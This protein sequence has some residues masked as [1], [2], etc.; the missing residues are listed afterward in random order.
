MFFTFNYLHPEVYIFFN[1]IISNTFDIVSNFKITHLIILIMK[2]T[3]ELIRFYFH[4]I[5]CSTVRIYVSIIIA[6]I[7]LFC[8]VD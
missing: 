1:C 7:H 2:M 5:M 3:N 6:D 8:I 4:V